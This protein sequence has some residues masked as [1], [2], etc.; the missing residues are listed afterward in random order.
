[1][2]RGMSSKATDGVKAKLPVI[3]RQKSKHD[4]AMPEMR[5]DPVRKD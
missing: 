5:V 1:M 3:A 2:A 4:S